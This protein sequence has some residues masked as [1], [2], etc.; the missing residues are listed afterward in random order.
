MI[1][2][3]LNQLQSPDPQQ[4]RQAIAALANTQDPAVLPYLAT[5][6]RGDPIP[7]LRDLA[8][9]AGR[10]IKQSAK[11]SA[12]GPA[13]GEK[14][15]I[16]AR[17]LELAK[18]YLDAAIGFHTRGDRTRSIENLGKALS[19]NPPLQ[20]ET[21]VINLIVSTTG[22]SV[23]AALPI[24]THPDR[25]AN[26]I[27][28]L[29]GKRKLKKKQTH[30]KGADKATWDNV[31]V[32]FI[33]FAL[34]IALSII[35]IM[36]LSLTAFDEAMDSAPTNS[37]SL[38]TG[39]LDTLLAASV[40]FTIVFAVFTGIFSAINMM[41]QGAAI[42]FSATTIFGGDG[43]LVYLYRRLV[44]FQ[45]VIM[46]IG[47]AAFVVITLMRSPE[48]LCF[49]FPMLSIAGTVIYYYLLSKLIGEVYNF[50]A[51][52]GCGA[53]L[54]SSVLLAVLSFGAQYLLISVLSIVFDVAT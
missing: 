51:G 42:H 20:K 53:L 52:S 15:Q 43:T 9:K 39:Q 21:Y 3:L 13:A 17:D 5:V 25:R 40:V 8:L 6:Y 22:L 38:M 18:G 35:A 10:F 2:E 33:I 54:I 4:R 12:G 19:L 45:T 31:L 11:D 30:G 1:D 28:Q 36:F 26:F 29:G 16:S 7:E 41:I 23:N 48:L 47:S 37:T 46:L 24:L 50:G 44:P 32:D 34:V 14:P 27:E 49:M